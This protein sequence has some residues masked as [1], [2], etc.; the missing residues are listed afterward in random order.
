MRF[1]F[2]LLALIALAL[3]VIAGVIDAV[4]SVAADRVVMTPLRAA[5]EDVGPSSL[6]ALEG[7]VARAPAFATTGLDVLLGQPASLF[8]LA[9]ALLLYLLGGIRLRRQRFSRR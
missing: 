3:A 5:W 2:R 7:L 9:L 4:Q 1:V 6:A 8:L